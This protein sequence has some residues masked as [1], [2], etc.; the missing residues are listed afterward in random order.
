[1]KSEKMLESVERMR[2]IKRAAGL[3]VLD[4]MQ[5]AAANPRSMRRAINAKCYDCS[6]FQKIEVK[7][8]PSKDCP[9]WNLRPWQG[10]KTVETE[11]TTKETEVNK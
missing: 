3:V 8:C 5:K 11:T 2:K 6:C 10:R 1:M 7:L 9:L 4:P